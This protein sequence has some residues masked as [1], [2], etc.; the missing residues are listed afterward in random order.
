MNRSH[1][2]AGELIPF[3]DKWGEQRHI[4]KHHNGTL[5]VRNT[6]QTVSRHLN[7]IVAR[8]MGARI[9]AKRLERGFSLEELCLR[10]GLASQT[11]KSRMW[12]IENAIRKEGVQMG[13]LHALA[14]ALECPIYDLLPSARTS[15]RLAQALRLYDDD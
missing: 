12:E 1:V 4:Y 10:A 15:A 6:R 8:M 7:Q 2:P 13:T 5:H 9:K 3:T 11:P 14:I